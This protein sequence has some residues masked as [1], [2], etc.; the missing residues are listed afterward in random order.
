MLSELTKPIH[1]T[2]FKTKY[3]NADPTEISK[4][5]ASSNVEWVQDLQNFLHHY[6]FKAIG[7]GAAGLVFEN[8]KYPWILKIFRKDYAYLRWVKFCLAHPDNP[9]CP[10]FRGKVIRITDE[11]YAIRVERLSEISTHL[12]FEM[13][14]ELEQ[15]MDGNPQND[16]PDLKEIAEF[17]N[18]NKKLL[19]FHQGNFMQRGNTPVVIDPL[20]NFFVNGKHLIDSA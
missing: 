8:P 1:V 12:Y 3:R 16:D 11:F 18:G 7:S 5:K 6:G 17:L 19:D 20:Y 14:E 4:S 15:L 13:E 2:Q 10:K 9:Y